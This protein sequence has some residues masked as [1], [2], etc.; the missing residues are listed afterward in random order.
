MNVSVL[1]AQASSLPFIPGWTSLRP[2]V[3]ELWLIASI[4]AVLLTP[5]FVRRPN[6]ACAAVSLV[7]LGLAFLTL[8]WV[9]PGE[10]GPADRFAPML[11]SDG[12]AFFWK[13]LL[14]LV[15]MGVVL[16]W[17]SSTA[18]TMHEG[19]G[20]EFFTLLLGATFGMSLMG[21]ASNLLML[22]LAVEM[23]SLPSYVL[24]GFRKTHRV[25]AEASLKYVLFGAAASAIMVYGLSLLYGLYGTLQLYPSPAGDGLAHLMATQPTSP[26]LLVVALLGLVVG[27]GFKISAVPFHFWC[28]D[29]FEGASIDVTTFLSVA[30]KGAG[31]VL[32]MR[33]VMAFGDAFGY[34]YSPI[35]A[36][37]AA[38]LGV[39]GAIT[40]TVGNTAAYLQ[41]NIKRLLAYSSIAHAGYMLCA[42]S[43]LLLGRHSRPGFSDPSA[44]A[45]QAILL[46]L[47]VYLFMNLGAFT[48]AAMVTRQSG[49]E[50]IRGFAGLGRRSPV[51]ALCMAAFMFSLI[52]LPP[53]AG[54]VAKVNVLWV[55]IQ[56]GG[57][58][59]WLVAVIGVNTIISLYFYARILRAMYL[60]SSDAPSF[61]GNPLGLAISTVCAAVL[62]L[63]FIGWAPLDRLTRNHSHLRDATA[64]AVDTSTA[65]PVPT[66]GPGGP[67][68]PTTAPATPVAAAR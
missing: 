19:D 37:L 68:A 57:W 44:A 5:F 14:L 46:Y 50:E 36:A 2:F 6:A 39:L 52:G 65:P 35:L 29:V 18:A 31:L 4:V 51:M 49:T 41:S 26:A 33:V 28:P 64:S 27:L 61:L 16:M 48:V 7:G 56:N 10:T 25:G 58:W 21:S 60:D 62:L 3:A 11:V 20:P 66:T 9:G 40:C 30:S 24:A 1:I 67:A 47:A 34:Q 12:V 42:L 15:T 54:F 38:V 32:L 55:L 8:L 45:A 22:F 63:L 53:F 43:L 13:L 23:A 59:W 17:F